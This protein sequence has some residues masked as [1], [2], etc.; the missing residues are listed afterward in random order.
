MIGLTRSAVTDTT[1]AAAIR[2]RNTSASH[3][4][5]RE[6]VDAISHT[7][8][9]KKTR[10][11]SNS[12]GRARVANDPAAARFDIVICTAQPRIEPTP[13]AVS[14]RIAATTTASKTR[15]TSSRGLGPP[16]MAPA[17]AMVIATVAAT[18]RARTVAMRETSQPTNAAMGS[19]RTSSARMNH[20]VRVGWP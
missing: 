10:N 1:N 20:S 3:S 17:I 15:S 11:V 5:G 13:Q 2:V 9:L 14:T 19:T 6:T 7:G 16:M 8:E 12:S 18:L 4:R